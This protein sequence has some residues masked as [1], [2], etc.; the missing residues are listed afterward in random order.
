MLGR[1]G[2]TE[3]FI[4][5]IFGLIIIGSIFLIIKLIKK[6][7][8]NDALEERLE[9]VEKELRHLKKER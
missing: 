5:I 9:M 4:V 8:N 3:L 7:S 2:F 6:A 1:I